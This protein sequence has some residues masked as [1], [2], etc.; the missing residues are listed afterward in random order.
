LYIAWHRLVRGRSF[1]GG[2]RGGGRHCDGDD[3]SRESTLTPGSSAPR[4]WRSSRGWHV[5]GTESSRIAKLAYGRAAS[6][7]PRGGGERAEAPSPSLATGSATRDDAPIKREP[8]ASCGAFGSCVLF[9]GIALASAGDAAAGEAGS[10][11]PLRSPLP[12]TPPPC[13]GR[14]QEMKPWT[15]TG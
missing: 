5:R 13:Q 12:E 1:D 3:P 8:S 15:Q 9:A 10:R 2:R 4:V 11:A 7:P 14:G 6:A